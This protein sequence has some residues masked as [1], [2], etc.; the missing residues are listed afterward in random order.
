VV[1][2]EAAAAADNVF[3]LVLVALI[4]GKYS[5]VYSMA[6]DKSCVP[7]YTTPRDTY[8]RLT[9]LLSYG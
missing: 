9:P 7:S 8:Y 1:V 5:V 6:A 2:V 3:V 4:V